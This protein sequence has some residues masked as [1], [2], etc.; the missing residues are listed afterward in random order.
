MKKLASNEKG[1]VQSSV[2]GFYTEEEMRLRAILA[3]SPDAIIVSDLNG[4]IV[5]CNQA[6]LDMGGFSSKDEVIGRSSFEFIAE[7]DCQRAMENLKKTLEQGLVK[8]VEYTFLA[9]DGRE[10]PAELSAGI[11]RDFSGN[12]TGFVAIT[13]DITERKKTEEELVR[14]S[15][16]VKMSTDSIVISDLDAK[17]IDVNEATLKMYGTDDKGDLI[18]KNSFD[19]IAPENREKALAGTKEVLE[20]GYVVGR[21]YNIITKDGSRIPVEMNVAIM[22]DADGKPIGFVGISRDITERKRAEETLRDSETNWRDSFNSLEDIMIII[23]KDYTIEKINNNGLKLLGKTREEVIGKKC[24]QV[25]HGMDAPCEF[26]SFKSTLKTGKMESVDRYVELFGKYFEIKSSPIFN[27]RGEIV[28]FVDLMRDVTKR[29]RTEKTLRLLSSAVKQSSEGIAVSDLQGNLL[30]VNNAFAAMHDYVPE[31]LVGKHLSIFHTPEQIPAVEAAN[32]QMQETGEFS[33]EICHARRDGTVFT[34]LMHNSL[35]RDEAGNPIGMIGTLRDITERKRAEEKLRLFSQSV[36]S[37]IDG[38]AIGNPEGKIIYTNEAFVRMFGYS[39]EELIGKA[40]T[41]FHPKDQIPKL[42]AALKATMEG[43]WT[44]EL[45]GKRKNGELFPIAISSSRVMDDEGK[46]TAI[47][48]SHR[49]ITERKQMEEKLRQYSERLEE[50]VQKR[51][52]ELLESERRYSVLVEEAN[53]GVVILQ[54]GKVVFANKKGP[55]IICYPRNELIGLPFEKLVDEKYRQLTRE[56]YDQRLRGERIPATYE[57]QVIAKN[58]ERVPV[59]LGAARINYQGRPADL[60][61]IR[62]IRDRKRVEEQR[63]KLEKLATM[64]ELA[65]MV[66]HDLRNPLTSI[67]TAGY[68]IKN[69]CPHRADAKCK[70]IKEMLDIIEQETLFADNIINDLL[71]FGAKRPLQKKRQN[72][73]KLVEVSLMV[74]N[75]PENIKVKR[76]LAK[77]TIAAVDGKQLERVFLNLTKNAVQAMPNGGKLTV[78]T[79]ETKDSIEIAFTDTGI[80]IPEENMSKIL[81]PLFTTK[82]KGIGMGLPICKRIVEQHGGTI[83]VKSKVDRGTVFTIK[84][85]KKGEE[86]NP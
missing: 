71:D 29:K 81:T 64:G 74:S 70:T 57:I 56:R 44:G 86:N 58:G 35:L 85:P 16:A 59:E 63:L 26:C 40:I 67:R 8:N 6:T 78:K 22:K 9:K 45:V 10:Y 47:L 68:Y 31:E 2:E 39:R 53:D 24:Y 36:D 21:E 73:N 42:E 51:T 17:I 50:L 12:P 34:T 61:I 83:D 80:G 77:N 19:L 38:M 43:G 7:R 84:L 79:T 82:A 41:S 5:E 60:L 1:V 76:K 4:N 37:S 54:D 28:R 52:E 33:G 13:K 66:A 3:S 48:A 75:I 14:L 11:I 20:K 72:I 18:G 25:V 30:F 27:E 62:D 69:T 46:I 32:R 49:D 15:S 65:T 55:E 23:N